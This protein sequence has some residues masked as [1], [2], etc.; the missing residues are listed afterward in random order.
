MLT[1][2]RRQEE[3]ETPVA[4]RVCFEVFRLSISHKLHNVE[5]SNRIAN[6]HLIGT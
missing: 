1:L 4:K 3:E 5:A 2:K 6:I